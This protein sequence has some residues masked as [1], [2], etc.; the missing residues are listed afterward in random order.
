MLSERTT[1]TTTKQILLY[2]DG[3]AGTDKTHVIR[4]TCHDLEARKATRSL[5]SVGL[6]SDLGTSIDIA[7][8]VASRSNV[9]EEVI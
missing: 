4:M 5:A 3:R 6:L 9:D 7:V 8:T 1:P 2:L